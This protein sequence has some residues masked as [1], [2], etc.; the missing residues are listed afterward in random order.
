[1]KPTAVPLD[2]LAQR[3]AEQQSELETLRREYETRQ[4][5]LAD[6]TR[7]KAKLEAQ[8][9]QVQSEIEAV[10]RGETP[11]PPKPGTAAPKQ[12]P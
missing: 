3:I 5:R 2:T 7:R 8:L 4:A 11:P 10:D 12:A 9:Q 6:L 1:M